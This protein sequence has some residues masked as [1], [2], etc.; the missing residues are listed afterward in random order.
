[1]YFFLRTTKVLGLILIFT[2]ILEL[3]SGYTYY[4]RSWE[5]GVAIQWVFDRIKSQLIA[6]SPSSS[7][8]ESSITK[9]AY[10]FHLHQWLKN[11]K[12]TNVTVA[13][14][15]IPS[16]NHHRSSNRIFFKELAKIENITFIDSTELFQKFPKEWL[17][18][19]PK[20]SHLSRFSHHLIA[21]HLHHWILEHSVYFTYNNSDLWSHDFESIKG[22]LP[23]SIDQT[24]QYQGRV[25]RVQTN[26]YGFRMTNSINS[27]FISSILILG[28]SFT[29]GTGVNTEDAYPNI[30]NRSLSN[31]LIVNAGVP[32]VGLLQEVTTYNQ[33]AL[34]LNPRLILLQV[35]DNDIK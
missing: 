26:S 14:L 12:E 31:I 18:N 29:F 17:Y 3:V 22:P 1:M 10:A 21:D 20:D 23:S 8:S 9:N 11:T 33:V 7:I 34:G 4:Q 6:D 25:Y 13:L 15:Y 19:L 16:F 32:G 28:D 30:L 2:F 27:N 24:R 5:Q 35:L